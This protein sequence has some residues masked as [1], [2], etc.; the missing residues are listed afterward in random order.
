MK[1]HFLTKNTTQEFDASLP[2]NEDVVRVHSFQHDQCICFDEAVNADVVAYAFL[3]G[4]VKMFFK[5]RTP[6]LVRVG[7]GIIGLKFSDDGTYLSV[8]KQENGRVIL[9]IIEIQNFLPVFTHVLLYSAS[10]IKDYYLSSTTFYYVIHNDF[11]GTILH[12]VRFPY[13]NYA[14]IP[15]V[16]ISNISFV[17]FHDDHV[18]CFDPNSMCLKKY[19]EYHT[20]VVA[21]VSPSIMNEHPLYIT[22]CNRNVW[23]ICAGSVYV[24]DIQNLELRASVNVNLQVSIDTVA[25]YGN[26][27]FLVTKKNADDSVELIRLTYDQSGSNEISKTLTRRFIVDDVSTILLRDSDFSYVTSSSHPILINHSGF[28]VLIPGIDYSTNNN[29]NNSNSDNS[30]S[31]NNSGNNSGNIDNGNNSGN[32]IN[33]LVEDGVEHYFLYPEDHEDDADV[34]ESEESESSDESEEEFTFANVLQQSLQNYQS[35]SGLQRVIDFIRSNILHHE[36]WS[37]VQQFGTNEWSYAKSCLQ[38]KKNKMELLDSSIQVHESIIVETQNI[39]NNVLKKER[40]VFSKFFEVSETIGEFDGGLSTDLDHENFDV[41]DLDIIRVSSGE[42]R[43]FSETDL[44]LSNY[45]PICKLTHANLLRTLFDEID[46]NKEITNC[47]TTGIIPTLNILIA[48][49]QDFVLEIQIHKT[50]L[51]KLRTWFTEQECSSE[52]RKKQPRIV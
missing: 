7:V 21:C 22:S 13:Y 45:S 16:R 48:Q 37:N 1:L 50:K 24:F 19:S 32:N 27:C 26:T 44:L 43:S 42:K 51:E 6:R 40:T 20:N 12:Q 47:V 33:V 34:E 3:N 49:L 52:P 38:K 14:L 15:G 5:N 17:H 39:I 25:S 23:C 46:S 35:K 10:D 30:N 2:S 41:N 29:N 8:L 31:D 28:L 18:I 36:Y 9:H 4:L 11:S